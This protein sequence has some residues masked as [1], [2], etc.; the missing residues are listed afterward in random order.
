MTFGS[1]CVLLVLS[2]GPDPLPRT[3][4]EPAAPLQPVIFPVQRG[5]HH[6][7]PAAVH[8]CPCDSVVLAVYL[9]KRWNFPRWLGFAGV[10]YVICSC[11][12]LSWFQLFETDTTVTVAA[13][14]SACLR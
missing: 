11:R 7:Q 6:L 13:T 10:M 5:D 4:A 3:S 12:R 8:P 9:A 14:L 1:C 2:A